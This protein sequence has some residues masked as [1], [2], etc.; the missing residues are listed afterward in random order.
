MKKYLVIIEPTATGYSAHVP[1]LPGCVS[2]GGTKEEVERN[3]YEAMKFHIE[4]MIAD[5]LA[6]PEGKS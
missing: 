4:G 2:T 5:G 1:D 3:I 6:V